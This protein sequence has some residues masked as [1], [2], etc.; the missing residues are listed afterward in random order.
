LSLSDFNSRLLAT[1]SP[2]EYISASLG[3]YF[4]SGES[5]K[6]NLTT[7]SPPIAD[8]IYDI[9]SMG[10]YTD[11]IPS[12]G[13]F[14]MYVNPYAFKSINTKV[15]FGKDVGDE[16]RDIH[17]IPN[18]AIGEFGNLGRFNVSQ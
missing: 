3:G 1:Q 8:I 7:P 5:I 6:V 10:M 13:D 11:H 17:R 9:D 16:V 4:A 14:S 18:F 15:H 2:L 12:V